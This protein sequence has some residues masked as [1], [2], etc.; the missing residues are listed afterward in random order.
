[1]FNP[2]K[3]QVPRAFGRPSQRSGSPRGGKRPG[4]SDDDVGQGRDHVLR[5]KA[6][7]PE[8]GSFTEV[9]TLASLMRRFGVCEER[10]SGVDKVVFQTE[11]YQLPAPIFEIAGDNTRA[12][13]LSHRSLTKMDRDDRIRACYL[14]ACLKYVNREYLTNSSVRERFGIDPRNIALASRLI[15]EA[16]TAGEILPYDPGAAPKMMK[17]VPWWAAEVSGRT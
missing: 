3:G 6:M 15:R 14:H 8:E 9:I 10:G 16:V 1:M 13:L 17:Y 4:A 5:K 2:F 12:V 11:L 7:S